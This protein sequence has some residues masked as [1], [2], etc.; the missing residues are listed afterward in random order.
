MARYLLYKVLFNIVYWFKA[1][2]DIG[3]PQPVIKNLAKRGKIAGRV[4]D[5]GC[6][7]G[8]TIIY[9]A[10]KGYEVMGI[11]FVPKAIDITSRKAE[12]AGL[13]IPLLVHDA[14]RLD[15]L[16]ET[17]DTIID[18][19]L[20]HNFSD[21]DRKRYAESLASVLK[22]GGS[23]YMLCFS[24]TQG[25][26]VGPRRVSKEEIYRT[27]ANGWEVRSIRKAKYRA[28]YP[29]GGAHA[30]LVSIRKN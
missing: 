9:L 27:F 4:L 5:V 30:W 18:A 3:R 10:R 25:G 23:Y 26:F 13:T 7:A 1:P 29:I 14:L 22:K 17:F 20:F 28:Y 11:D 24:D 15:E 19:G 8:D 21:G 16:N 6:G 2:W 12:K